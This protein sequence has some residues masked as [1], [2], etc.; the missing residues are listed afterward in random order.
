VK[1]WY[2]RGPLAWLLWPVSWIFLAGV[3]IRRLMYQLR[4]L[5]SVHPGIPVIVVGNLYVGGTGKTP[6]TIEIVRALAARG[7]R[8]GVISRGHLGSATESRLVTRSD[9]P[10]VCG[11]EP[12]LI[13]RST[14]APVAIGRRRIDAARL[15]RMRH[16][17]CDCIVCDDGLQHW[18]LRRDVEIALIDER[19]LGNGWM[20]PA[21]P[22]RDPASRLS[23][24][25]AI[26]IHGNGQL[27][28]DIGPPPRFAMRTRLGTA[29]RL[30]DAAHR[31]DLATIAAD[32]R[33]RSLTIVAAAGIGVPDRFFAML[34]EYTLNIEEMPLPDHFDFRVD[35]FASVRADRILITEKDAVKCA[36]RPALALDSRIWVVPLVA[37]IDPALIET[38]LTSLGH[39]T[40]E[41]C[42]GSA[43]A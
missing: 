39:A 14:D 34:R 13:A 42:I 29:W 10:A 30:T 9:D 11:D 32:Q 36:S 6:L 27:D 2:R 26:V 41:S 19:R 8:P 21:G 38:T 1:F 12:L 16:P 35:P 18:A 25:D 7:Y 33:E 22:L 15:L 37:A 20:L 43:P 28:R 40:E 4:L 5:G 31:V 24:V 17:D 3:C 23:S